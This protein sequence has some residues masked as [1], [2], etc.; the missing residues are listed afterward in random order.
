MWAVYALPEALYQA[1]PPPFSWEGCQCSQFTPVTLS[2]QTPLALGVLHPEAWEAA[3]TPF[4]Q[5]QPMVD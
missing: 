3:H 5:K 4:P 2:S 1:G